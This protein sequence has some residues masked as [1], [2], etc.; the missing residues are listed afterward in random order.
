MI[1][2]Y[3]TKTKQET[4]IHEVEFENEIPKNWNI[5]YSNS[6]ILPKTLVKY[7]SANEFGFKVLKEGKIW[8]THPFDFNDPFDCSIHLWDIETFPFEETKSILNE[9]LPGGFP[10][11]ADV[12]NTR[13]VYLDIMLRFIGIYCLNEKKKSDL[14][15]G[16]YSNHKGF[17]IEFNS[18]ILNLV[19]GN[20]PFK[21]EYKDLEITDKIIMNPGFSAYEL[22]PKILRW[23]TLKK[24]DWIHENE[25]RYLFFDIDLGNTNRER[26]FPLTAINEIVLGNKFF[27]A[28]TDD[29]WLNRTTSEFTFGDDFE[30]NFTFKIL[31]FL[32]GNP[33]IKLKQVFINENFTLTEKRIFIQKIKDNQ[34]TI[35]TE[36]L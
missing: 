26:P 9:F 19:F 13:N 21:I 7:Y 31:S 22:Y 4:R 15:W 23:V 29:K 34:V 24:K 5:K 1:K 8:A 32:F 10:S 20:V 11:D 33:N 25:W 12:Y 16:Y 17:S 18:E 35:E 27:S 6:V 28:A 3:P 14:F 36:Q 2:S 30:N